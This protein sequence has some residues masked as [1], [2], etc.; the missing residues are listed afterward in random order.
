M[1]EK[2]VKESI[3][4]AF[5]GIMNDLTKEDIE[6]LQDLLSVKMHKLNDKLSL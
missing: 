1:V 4:N 3:L 5:I 6:E 2:L